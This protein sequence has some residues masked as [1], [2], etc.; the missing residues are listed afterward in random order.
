MKGVRQIAMQRA[1]LRSISYV[2]LLIAVV[3]ASGPSLDAEPIASGEAD[4]PAADESRP[5]VVIH[6]ANTAKISAG[7]LALAQQR[8]SE[9]YD[10]AGVSID[11]RGAKALDD[12]PL[13]GPKWMQV[14]VVLAPDRLTGV[15]CGANHLSEDTMGVAMVANH[16]L[17]YVFTD[18]IADL[19]A[20]KSQLTSSLIGD[21]IAHE[22]GHLLLPESGHTRDGVMR[23]NLE[24]RRHTA[25][26][27]TD[28]QAAA[29]RERLAR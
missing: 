17:A 27:F 15:I 3:A 5:W 9:I 14:Y 2:G 18:R 20:R 13:P 26:R 11:W 29:L 24:T 25:G 19:A 16:Y 21:V 10:S 12:D 7:Q 1:G 4:A 22:V 28:A 8:A 23:P 6:L